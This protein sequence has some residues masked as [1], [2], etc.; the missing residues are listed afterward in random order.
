MV[1]IRSDGEVA[2]DE[3][4]QKS[5]GSNVCDADNRNLGSD[6]ASDL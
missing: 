3:D 1:D 6:L 2:E 5:F 4:D